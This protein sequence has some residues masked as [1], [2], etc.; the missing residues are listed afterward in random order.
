MEESTLQNLSKLIPRLTPHLS[1][2]CLWDPQDCEDI[3]PA[4]QTHVGRQS[5]LGLLLPGSTLFPKLYEGC[6]THTQTQ[7]TRFQTI[8]RE[9]K[10]KRILLVTTQKHAQFKKKQERR[11]LAYQDTAFIQH[12]HP[13]II[14]K[15]KE[16][17]HKQAHIKMNLY[18]YTQKTN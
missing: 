1:W 2:T 14:F 15:K 9:N 11:K 18:S 8:K 12:K 13:Q 16:T 10:K 6:L 7:T 5:A 17:N 3:A 4:Q